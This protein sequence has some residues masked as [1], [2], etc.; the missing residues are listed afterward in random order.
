MCVSAELLK[1]GGEKVLQWLVHLVRV[2]W[3][4]EK[5][6]K[7]WLKQVTIP[8]HKKGCN[9]DCDILQGHHIA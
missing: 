2:V 8:L 9:R 1:L 7:D 3:E 6:P 5:V 4:E